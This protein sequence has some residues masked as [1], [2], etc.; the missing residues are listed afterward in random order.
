MSKGSHTDTL[1]RV[2]THTRVSQSLQGKTSHTLNMHGFR[3][4][5]KDSMQTPHREALSE[6]TV[7]HMPL[8]H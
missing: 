3:C 1:D 8:N 6:P 2:I 5:L 7:S 4:R